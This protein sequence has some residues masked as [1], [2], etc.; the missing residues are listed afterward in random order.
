MD[1]A[2]NVEFRN[3]LVALGEVFDVKLSPQRQALY[4][5]GL[6]DLPFAAV[7]KGL[8]RAVQTCTFFPKPAEL[9]T[10]AIGDAED[11][12]EAAWMRLRHALSAVGAYSS[13]V[14]TD[15]ALGEAIGACFGS[16]PEACSSDLSP[17]MWA[18]KRKEFGRMYRVLV[19][20]QL[21]GARYL[22]GLC[23]A[24]NAGHREWMRFTPVMRLATEGLERLTLEQAEQARTTIAAN[25]HGFKRLT[26]GMDLPG[27]EGQSA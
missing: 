16:W 19:D 10:L 26:D 24:Q 18:S 8:N 20:R 7:A 23:E 17:E 1:I 2:D 27:Q 14:V 12:I 5:E 3:R 11:H 6:R 4:F 21:I 9:R 22:P 13:L 15:P 25:S